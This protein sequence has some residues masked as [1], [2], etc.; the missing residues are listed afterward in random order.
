MKL[1]LAPMPRSVDVSG[2]THVLARERVIMLHGEARA[3]IAA[4]RRL[5][6][7]LERYAGMRWEVRAGTSVAESEGVVAAIDHR[8]ERG[9]G[10]HLTIGDERIGLVARDGAGLAHGFSTLV[11]LVR[12]FGRRL[13]RL[14]IEDHPDFAHRGVML[15]VSRDKVPTMETLYGLVDMLSEWKI[16]QLQLYME[17]TFAY[18]RHR[19]VWKDASPLT[20][21]EILALDAYCR[22]RHVEL[23]PN[24]NSFGHMERWLIHKPYSEL[25]EVPGGIA[26][27]HASMLLTKRRKFSTLNPLDPR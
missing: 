26:L 16:N 22:E 12:Q 8:V 21:E 17:H 6:E 27:P 9:E 18:Q 5:Q 19:A 10:Y 23:V 24:Q 1:H 14:H 15:D 25:A 4:A 2:G 13:P 20:G 7:A 3:E 11:Q